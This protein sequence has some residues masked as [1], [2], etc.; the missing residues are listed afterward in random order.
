MIDIKWDLLSTSSDPDFHEYFCDICRCCGDP[1]CHCRS[2][3]AKEFYDIKGV[4]EEEKDSLYGE[5]FDCEFDPTLCQ[6]CVVSHGDEIIRKVQ[7]KLN[8]IRG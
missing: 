3:N 4:S 8:E 2:W 5:I 6:K 1:D 7:E